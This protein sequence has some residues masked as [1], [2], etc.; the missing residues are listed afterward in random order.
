MT[1]RSRQ[2]VIAVSGSNTNLREKLD[3]SNP[4]QFNKTKNRSEHYETCCDNSK[5]T[6]NLSNQSG[7]S[8]TDTFREY[9][10]SR[11]M[12]TT[13]IVDNSFS[14]RTGDFDPSSVSED[15]LSDSLLYCLDNGTPVPENNCICYDSF[16]NGGADDSKPIHE[17]LL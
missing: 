4:E 16:S 7:D 11:S 2:P 15:K 13:S 14:S 3:D 1:P 9:L 8:L 6:T 12:L 10:C 5:E 17:T